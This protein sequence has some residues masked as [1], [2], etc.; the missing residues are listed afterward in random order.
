MLDLQEELLGSY[1]CTDVDNAPY[2]EKFVRRIE[3]ETFYNEYT[4]QLFS[5]NQLAAQIKKYG[6]SGITQLNDRHMRACFAQA[7][8]FDQKSQK[9]LN[10]AC[11]F[12]VTDNKVSMAQMLTVAFIICPHQN[13]ES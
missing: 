7:D 9:E 11:Y 4:Q 2:D 10:R 5:F 1:S 3:K 6:G 8:A 13:A 12:K